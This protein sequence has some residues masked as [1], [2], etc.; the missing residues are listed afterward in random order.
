MSTINK[1]NIREMEMI[2]GGDEL[3]V[4]GNTYHVPTEKDLFKVPNDL[5]V[6]VTKHIIREYMNPFMYWLA[7]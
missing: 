4:D 3:K 7:H 1:M 2:N 5:R 6:K